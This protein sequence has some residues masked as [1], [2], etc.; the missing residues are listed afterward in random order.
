M[1]DQ[2][3]G[4]GGAFSQ[5]AQRPQ[6]AADRD[7]AQLFGDKEPGRGSNA[8]ALQI[9]RA[10][11]SG[12]IRVGEHLPKERDLGQFFG[13]SRATLREALRILE[14]SGLIE[15]RRGSAGGIF[16]CSPPVDRMGATLGAL[17]QLGNVT[18]Q[19]FTEFR[20]TFEMETAELAA[21]RATPEA[22]ARLMGTVANLVEV[23]NRPGVPWE[24]YMEL[25]ILFH[26][27]LAVASGN[28]IR[29]AVMLALNSVFRQSVLM[30]SSH[31]TLAWRSRQASELLGVAQAVHQHKPQVARRLMEQHI[32]ESAEVSEQLLASTR[33]ERTPAGEPQ[34]AP[35]GAEAPPDGEGPANGA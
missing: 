26:E 8:V 35:H 12:A 7:F 17:I 28:P 32:R 3:A 24:T 10:I 16:V 30:V 34:A 9:Q 22:V 18:P 2:A 31:D 14:A 4:G 20:L 21:R 1:T 13:V 23:A 29:E 33:Y 11:L 19:H 25:D 5:G 15:V 6:D 27:H